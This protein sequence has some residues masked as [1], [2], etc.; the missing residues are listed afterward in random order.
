RSR[1]IVIHRGRRAISSG[2]NEHEAKLFPS[3]HG[4]GE[5]L[6]IL[7]TLINEDCSKNHTLLNYLLQNYGYSYKMHFDVMYHLLLLLLLLLL[8]LLITNKLQI[9]ISTFKSFREHKTYTSQRY[10]KFKILKLYK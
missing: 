6:P 7:D 9:L 8:V 4:Q 1:E 3:L 10:N 5:C 2:I